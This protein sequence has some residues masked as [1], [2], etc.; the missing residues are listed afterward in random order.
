MAQSLADITT[1][2]AEVRI[3]GKYYAQVETR[4]FDLWLANLPTD[5][6]M[7]TASYTLHPVGERFIA[8]I[9]HDD[10]EFETFV[11][12]TALAAKRMYKKLMRENESF[13]ECGWNGQR[14]FAG[15][16]MNY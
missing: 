11:K 10:N 4:S 3:D 14:E 15:H 6:V 1:Q 7:H 13:K 9:Q 16:W 12:S 8:Y 5:N 2:Y